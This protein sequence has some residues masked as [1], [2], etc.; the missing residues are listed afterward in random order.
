MLFKKTFFAN[1]LVLQ[2][3]VMYFLPNMVIS[4]CT[5]YIMNTCFPLD[6]MGC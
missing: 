3:A 6:R 4:R 2:K 5:V 1:V